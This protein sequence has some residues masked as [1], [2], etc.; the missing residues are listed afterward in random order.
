MSTTCAV[1]PSY[2]SRF[3]PTRLSSKSASRPASAS[4]LPGAEWHFSQAA[5]TLRFARHKRC[6]RERLSLSASARFVNPPGLL[7][8]AARLLDLFE[9]SLRPPVERGQRL[10][11]RLTEWS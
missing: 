6:T 5:K 2:R 4:R 9:V 8:F 11:E 7:R 3:K 10:H 1:W